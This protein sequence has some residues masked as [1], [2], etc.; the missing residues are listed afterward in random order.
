MIKRVRLDGWAIDRAL[1][2]AEGLGLTG[3]LKE[4]AIQYLKGLQ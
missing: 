2:E 4:S 1:L 3:A